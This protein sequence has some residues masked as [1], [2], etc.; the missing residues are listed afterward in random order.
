MTKKIILLVTAFTAIFM[1]TGC[2]MLGDQYTDTQTLEY[3]NVT[4][5]TIG[6]V[7]LSV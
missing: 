3:D 7:M 6:S 1:V 2:Q 5:I 4:T